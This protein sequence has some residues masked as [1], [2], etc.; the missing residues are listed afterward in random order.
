MPQ[1]DRYDPDALDD[2]EYDALSDTARRD[3]EAQ[4]RERDRAEGRHMA[5]RIRRGLL[6]G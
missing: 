4:M 3:A 5:G 2:S 6:Y 1:L